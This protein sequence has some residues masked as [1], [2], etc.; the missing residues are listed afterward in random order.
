M[1]KFR[2]DSVAT[3]A[4]FPQS[5]QGQI[6]SDLGGWSFKLASGKIVSPWRDEHHCSCR[7]RFVVNLEFQLLLV[8]D[9]RSR[10]QPHSENA[11]SSSLL[12]A[13]IDC[14]TDDACSNQ[15]SDQDSERALGKGQR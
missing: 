2:L 12:R 8:N 1:L 5:L 15:E 11:T 3:V 13:V 14:H 7:G 6:L 10:L 4:V 9:P